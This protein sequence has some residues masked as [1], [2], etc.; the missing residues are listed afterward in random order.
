MQ[1]RLKSFYSQMQT[2]ADYSRGIYHLVMKTIKK[3]FE[4]IFLG[5]HRICARL[6]SQMKENK[7][8]IKF[9]VWVHSQ[10]TF[11]EVLNCEGTL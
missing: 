3:P 11:T 9:T 7:F 5:S 8:L 1:I 6:I 10:I 4:A 2:T